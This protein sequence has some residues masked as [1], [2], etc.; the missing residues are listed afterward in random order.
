MPPEEQRQ[1]LGAFL[2]ARRG[3]LQPEDVGLAQG[4]SH[5]R[6]PGLRREELAQLAGISVSWYT[7]LE[8]GRDV[9]LS[10][11]AVARLAEA[12]QLTA[13][14]REYLLTLAREDPLGLQAAPTETVSATLRDILDAQ[15][16]NPAYLID[17]RLNLLAWN[18][19]SS[20]SLRIWLQHRRRS[21]ICC[22]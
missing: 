20:A 17:A 2:R 5:R 9:Q 14:E 21:V 7:R 3:A 1:E 4:V 10:A 16:D 12:L 19:A 6:T 11:K 13:A 22:G 18:Q 8:Q 15:G